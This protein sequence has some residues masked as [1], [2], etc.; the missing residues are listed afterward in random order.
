MARPAADDSYGMFGK[1]P[2]PEPICLAEPQPG[3]FTCIPVAGGMGFGIELSQWLAGDAMQPYDHAE[4]YAGQADKD[5][6]H[7]YTYSAYPHSKGRTGKR[8]LP[9]PPAEL[10]GSLWSS[11]ILEL[12]QAQREG[13]VAWC[14]A[15]PDVGYSFLDYDALALH[16]LHIPMPGLQ[17][18]IA[19][20]GHLI[21]SQYVDS[22]WLSGPLLKGAPS[23]HLFTDGRWP[24]FVKPGDL[25]GMLLAKKAQMQLRARRTR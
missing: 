21:C 17:S 6:P 7:G 16:M 8:P 13:I 11:G 23:Y 10:P 5:G 22:A 15:R 12:T 14:E 4:V 20:T 19:S 24:G 2:W 9:C 3:D 1:V 18:Y 25:A